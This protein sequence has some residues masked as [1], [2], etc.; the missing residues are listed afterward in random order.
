M[1]FASCKKEANE[2]AH[3]HHHEHE[4]AEGHEHGDHDEAE[5]SEHEHGGHEEHAADVIVL[6]PEVA[7]RLGVQADT[8]KTAP[9][10]R[11]VKVSGRVMPAA[12]GSA[13]VSAPTSGI[14]TLRG[15]I[16]LGSQVRAGQVIGTV[17]SDGVS[18]GD[19]NR[20]AKVDLD[21]AKAEFERISTLYKDRLVTLGQYNTA[22]AAYERAQAAYSAPAANGTAVSPIS[23]VITALNA[24]SGQ[25]VET[26]APIAS[27]A[28]SAR[29]TLRAEV[30]FKH[31]Q[32]VA[33]ASDARVVVP[34]T[35]TDV[36][37]SQLDGRRVDASGSTAG[38][39]GGYVPV[40]FSLRNDGSLI[41]GSAVEVYLLG[42]DKYEAISV[43]VAALSEQQGLYFVFV[44]LDE[45]CYR[46][47]PVK[48]GES[49]GSRV[50]IL[51][52]LKSGDVVVAQGVTAVKLAQAGSNVPEGHTH[53][54]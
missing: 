28:T 34:A 24:Q 20:I 8:V 39:Q 13:I 45:D 33:N 51:D 21:A 41:P 38:A 48:I 19:V 7:A 50:E 44:K 9:F 32:A 4:H 12:E 53:S 37:L 15:G 42:N 18:G 36:L 25:Y 1:P 11:A 47:V 22:K 29:L 26:G 6:E 2:L 3:H 17:K 49:D 27:V 16:N 40:T 23:G 14:L 10:G 31:Y 52:G 43:P 35:Q 30:P 54:H 5:H 46:K